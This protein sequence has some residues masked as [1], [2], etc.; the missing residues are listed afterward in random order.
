MSSQ[1]ALVWRLGHGARPCAFFSIRPTHFEDVGFVLIL[2]S[3]NNS[4]YHELKREKMEH[5]DMAYEI[6][7]VR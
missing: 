1:P 2:L 3:M 7:K 5:A 4:T 6:Q